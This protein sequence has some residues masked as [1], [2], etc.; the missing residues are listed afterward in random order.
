[1]VR[2]PMRDEDATNAAPLRALFYQG[3]E[4]GCIVNRRVDYRGAL[5]AIT[6]D[7]GIGAWTRHY[8][9][10]GSQ[11]DGIRSLH[12][13]S[14]LFLQACHMIGHVPFIS[15]IAGEIDARSL[16]LLFQDSDAGNN[17]LRSASLQ[18][19]VDAVKGCE[20]AQLVN[21][22][23]DERKFAALGARQGLR[24]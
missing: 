7:N 13:T 1:M 24:G 21:G 20:F 5:D 17:V 15:G 19:L 18:G 6:Q 14:F 23:E 9:R 22:G 16:G 3:F 12:L 4:I 11:N 8:R 10:V 2:M